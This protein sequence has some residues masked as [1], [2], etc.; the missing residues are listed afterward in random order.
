MACESHGDSIS[1]ITVSVKARGAWLKPAVYGCLNIF[2]ATSI[3]FANKAVLSV[4]GF[5]FTTALTLLHTV[6]TFVGMMV[7]SR[8]GLFSP[9]PV[10]ASQVNKSAACREAYL[11]SIPKASIRPKSIN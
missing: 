6:T 1:G 5:G 10:P 3:V 9:K 8:M 11:L 2:V 4:Y 7:F